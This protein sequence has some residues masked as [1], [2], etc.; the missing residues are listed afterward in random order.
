MTKAFSHKSFLTNSSAANKSMRIL[1]NNDS[2]NNIKNQTNRRE[3]M[4]R[5]TVFFA[6]ALAFVLSMALAAGLSFAADTG[7]AEITLQTEAA[8]KP[9]VFPHKK[10]QETIEC[11]TC[12]HTKTAD[13]K[14]GPYV[15]GE[16]A[17]CETC[18]NATDMTDPKLN[19]LKGAG[20][21]L[22]KGCHK[23]E[24]AAGKNAPTKCSGCHPKKS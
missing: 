12:H 14:Q 2:L 23:K 4:M 5:K 8:K 6:T 21:E 24:K 19:S 3:M 15:A 9:A 10:H 13:G 16:E 11:A 17:K 1:L 22:C 7:P 18:H 20:H